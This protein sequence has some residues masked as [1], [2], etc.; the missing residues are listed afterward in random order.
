MKTN[1]S[2]EMQ[3]ITF[4]FHYSTIKKLFTQRIVRLLAFLLLIYAFHSN[5]MPKRSKNTD[6]LVYIS[7]L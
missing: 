2:N 6:K 7:Y 3:R 5:F 1:K 4:G